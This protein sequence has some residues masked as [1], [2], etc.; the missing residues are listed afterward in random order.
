[1]R[2]VRQL[3]IPL[4]LSTALVASAGPA[5]AAR[6]PAQVGAVQ[7]GAVAKAPAADSPAVAAARARAKLTYGQ[8]A[9]TFMWNG[10]STLTVLDPAMM[11]K[12]NFV[13]TL[14][15][16]DLRAYVNRNF[17]WLNS[18]VKG[19]TG[20]DATVAADRT[21]LTEAV[22]DLQY[23]LDNQV[24]ADSWASAET[25]MDTLKYV[26]YDTP[27]DGGRQLLNT[28][29]TCVRTIAFSVV[30]TLPGLIYNIATNQTTASLAVASVGAGVGFTVGAL[31]ALLDI[32]S[33][34]R[35]DQVGDVSRRT[36]EVAGRVSYAAYLMATQATQAAEA[37]EVEMADLG[38]R[39]DAMEVN[40]VA[41]LQQPQAQ[42]W[43][44]WLW[45]RH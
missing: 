32:R 5:Q 25:A 13:T 31:N 35:F 28:C 33:S 30:G 19:V 18:W 23:A 34:H 16:A 45:R 11:A 17:T 20:Y 15:D 3:L 2:T 14:S 12:S 38:A 43:F 29:G 8:D 39:L 36:L 21:H 6:P 24:P 44:Q 40:A 42:N 37:Q 1:M 7:T 27:T 10:A 9:Y 41:G 4:A 26:Q 22:E